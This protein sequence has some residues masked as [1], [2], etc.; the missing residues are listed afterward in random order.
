MNAQLKKGGAEALQQSFR[1]RAGT[2]VHFEGE[3]GGKSALHEMKDE[4]IAQM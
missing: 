4:Q 1:A 2:A 3:G